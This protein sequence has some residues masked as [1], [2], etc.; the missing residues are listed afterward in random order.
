M[1]GDCAPAG[2]EADLLVTRT[3]AIPREGELSL[4]GLQ[5]VIDSMGELGLLSAPLPAP[6]KYVDLS[7][8]ERARQ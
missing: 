6:D 4:A 7:Y 3:R 2:E 1:L 5:V 8:L